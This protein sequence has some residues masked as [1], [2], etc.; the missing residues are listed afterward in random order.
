MEAGAIDGADASKGRV[1]YM[2]TCTTC[3]G[4]AL[5][6]MPHQGVNLRDSKFVAGTNDQKLV[7]FIKTGRKPA[8]PKNT[9]GL[10]MPPRGGN[11]ALDD[12]GLSNIVAYLRQVQ[13]DAAVAQDPS[14]SPSTR[15]MASVAQ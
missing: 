7:A 1:L 14:Q 5:T 4:Q 6:G 3:H 10:P 13:R 11:P 12:D 9:T 15:P 8:D 2:Q